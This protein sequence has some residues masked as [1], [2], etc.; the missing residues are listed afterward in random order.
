MKNRNTIFTGWPYFQAQRM[1]DNGIPLPSH[2][3]RI[4]YF[5]CSLFGYFLGL[6]TATI[7]S[8]VR[9]REIISSRLHC[10]FSS[11]ERSICLDLLVTIYARFSCE[12]IKETI[13]S[14]HLFCQ[15]VWSNKWM[16]YFFYA[17]KAKTIFPIFPKHVYAS[18]FMLTGP[19]IGK[20]ALL[21]PV[22]PP[23]A[24]LGEKKNIP[25]IWLS[26]EIG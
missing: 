15:Y 10:E 21:Y 13:V 14:F 3:H 9:E 12:I 11:Q 16:S 1:A 6:L 8:E 7:S 19:L 2:W 26:N 18:N 24:P 4:S 25:A 17:T 23:L 22:V 20:Q 5:H